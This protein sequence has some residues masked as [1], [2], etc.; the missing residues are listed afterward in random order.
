M[1][2]GFRILCIFTITCLLQFFSQLSLNAFNG[3]DKELPR[4]ELLDL[5]VQPSRDNGGSIVFSI[6]TRDDRNLVDQPKME[7][8]YAFQWKLGANPPP[9][10]TSSSTFR[11]SLSV[12][13]MKNLRVQNNLGVFQ[14][15]YAFGNIP[16]I[17]VLDGSCAEFRD[18]AKPPVVSLN[19]PIR[20]TNTKSNPSVKIFSG[21]LLLP[22]LIDQSGRRSKPEEVSAKILSVNL[23]A[24]PWPEKLMQLCLSSQGFQ[25]LQKSDS[26]ITTFES[27]ISKANDLGVEA[28]AVALETVL[29]L[30]ARIRQYQEFIDSPNERSWE[31]IAYCID[32]IN[33]NT[34]MQQIKSWT[35]DQ[36]KKTDETLKLIATLN[37]E[38]QVQSAKKLASERADTL[39]LIQSTI[40]E[41]NA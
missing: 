17:P 28:N 40:K 3:E 35:A 2:I 12:E 34:L 19:S 33:P 37:K 22:Q 31:K 20:S 7:I 39:S 10:C 1:K 24:F 8:N 27:E 41:K 21:K 36:K 30:K 23:Y 25:Q 6:R 14:T 9:K 16:K 18:L 4:V 15:F 29:E 38:Q 26:I 32:G 13:E 5:K 11:V